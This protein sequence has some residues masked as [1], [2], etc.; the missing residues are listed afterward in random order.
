MG[1]GAGRVQGRRI[2]P[3]LNEERADDVSIGEVPVAAGSKPSG[4]LAPTV[5]IVV[6]VI[7]LDQL[8]KWWALE[9]LDT[10]Q[11]DVVW[12]LRFNLVFN[13]GA[14]FSMGGGFGPVFGAVATL[15]A[16]GLLRWSRNLPSSVARAACGLV[17]G[18]ALGNVADR[19]FRAGDGFG[20]GRVVDFIDLQWWPVFN[21]ADMAV[22]TGALVLIFAASRDRPSPDRAPT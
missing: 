3:P 1:E 10:R 13:D 2:R 11:I 21:V 7:I 12:T 5:A 22:V 17:A 4:G 16:F 8:T 15:V 19:V 18:G 6:A 20:R 14:S 9:A